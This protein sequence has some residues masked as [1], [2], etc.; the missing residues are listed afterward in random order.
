MSILAEFQVGQVLWSIFWFFLFFLWIWLVISIFADIIR[1]DDLSGWGKALWAIAIIFL[2]FLGV[3]LYLIVRGGSMGERS[4]EQARQ[5]EDAFKAYVQD[6]AGSSSPSDQ[7][8]NLADLHA[9][10][11]L[12][13]DEYAQA[14][15]K[16]LDS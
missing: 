14:K 9:S 12:S 4:A 13:D 7:L 2:P 16:V 3:F 6:A 5:S 11:K 8:A 15:A 1:S 10:G